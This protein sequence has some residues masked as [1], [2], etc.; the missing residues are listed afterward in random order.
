MAD[1]E[2][3]EEGPNAQQAQYWNEVAGPKWVAL[4]QAINSQIEPIG[5]EAMERLG[6]QPGDS[7]LDVGCGC[8]HTTHELGRRVGDAGRALGMD[9]SAPMLELARGAGVKNVEFRA[10]DVQSEDLGEDLYDGIFSRFGVMFFAD[11]GAAFAN[12]RRALRPGGRMVFV[13]WQEIGKNPWMAVPGAAVAPLVEMPPRPSPHAPGPF[14]FADAERVRGLLTSAGFSKAEYEGL[15]RSLTI[16]RGMSRDELVNFS[17]Q[18]GPAG[19]AM[20]EADESLRGQLRAA[21]DEAIEPYLAGGGLEMESAT[22]IFT[23]E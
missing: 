15:E 5:I 20:R 23:A 12:L 1:Q 21:V 8:G 4:D 10:A 14:A 22:W 3:S 19:A 7:V 16:G 17:L 13:C 9:L 2:A 6:V 11:S 18:M